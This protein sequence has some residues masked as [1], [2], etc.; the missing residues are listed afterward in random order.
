MLFTNAQK[1]LKCLRLDVTEDLQDPHTK[2][3]KIL[4]GEI[5]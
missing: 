2:S 1:T 4:L 3:H 5:K